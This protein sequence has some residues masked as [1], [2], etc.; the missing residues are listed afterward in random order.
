MCV[1]TILSE[2]NKKK[3]KIEKLPSDAYF[4]IINFVLLYFFSIIFT[5]IDNLQTKSKIEKE[6]EEKPLSRLAL[7]CHGQF[8]TKNF[9]S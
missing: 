3:K 4:K 6:E 2:I 9:A 1:I 8:D 5:L 7:I